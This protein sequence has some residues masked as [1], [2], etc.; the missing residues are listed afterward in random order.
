MEREK[1]PKKLVF[2]NGII[3]D[4]IKYDNDTPLE[5][6]ITYNLYCDEEEWQL[7]SLNG[8]Y[9]KTKTYLFV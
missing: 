2:D 7:I 1:L 6:G 9:I 5:C 4:F 8:I 3:I